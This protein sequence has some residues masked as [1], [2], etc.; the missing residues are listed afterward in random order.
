MSNPIVAGKH[1]LDILTTG[2]YKDPKIIFRE[3]I[4]NSTDAIDKAI[5]KGLLQDW[6]DGKVQI[7][8]NT[9]KSQIII[10][11]NGI[12]VSKSIV[13][14]SLCDIGQSEKDYTKD[15]GFRGIGRLGGLG[16]SSK[17][18]FVTS[19]YGENSKSIVEWD[20]M[21]LKDLITPGKY[22]EYDLLGVVQEVTSIKSEK[23]EY[24]AHYFI[25]EL[26]GI[27]NQF[28]ELLNEKIINDYLSQV[29][30]VPFHGQKFVFYHDCE[31]GIKNFLNEI[32]KPLEE[33]NIY[34]NSNPNPIFKPY[35]N[36]FK[37]GRG[38]SEKQDNIS[39]IKY[40]KEYDQKGH[41]LFWG[42]YAITN[43]SG[44]IKDPLIA[45]IRLR[46]R[47]ILIGDN[48]FLEDLFTQARFNL[49]FI[50]EIHVY[51][52]NLIPNARRDDFEKNSQY[53]SLIR[54]LETYTKMLSKLP[55]T[56][57]IYNAN[58]NNIVKREKELEAIQEK[59]NSGIA[60]EVE[61]SNLHNKRDVI[62][63]DIKKSKKALSTVKNKIDAKVDQ[64]I[65]R[66]LEKVE[67]LEEKT[68]VIENGII[69]AE[70]NIIKDKALS[71][72]SKSEKKIVIRVFDIIDSELDS[73]IAKK[74]ESKIIDGLKNKRN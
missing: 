13:R 15:R 32:G 35:K 23:E 64:N 41:M 58:S 55:P 5:Q 68:K 45:G 27:D 49:W 25:A 71:G 57:S 74:L 69:D 40:F 6:D 21:K 61:R 43:F 30:P 50:G 28:S 38:E 1:I 46:K 56:Y 36:Y 63:N 16:Y 51:D 53:E 67:E 70:Y 72:Y 33:Y 18:R 29:A 65:E 26:S 2:M 10:K 8:L 52:D 60:S 34:L 22:M 17:L 9:K 37:A 47:N 3:Y 12:G 73:E 62:H 42:W 7:T 19:F 59:I 20:C 11:D 14:H 24:G 44:Y 31:I 4:Q 66:L 54:K 39:N 48:K